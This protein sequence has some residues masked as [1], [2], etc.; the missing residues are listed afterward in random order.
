MDPVARIGDEQV[1]RRRCVGTSLLLPQM[2]NVWA[3]RVFRNDEAICCHDHLLG[4][5]YPSSDCHFLPGSGASD[6]R[7][8]KR[9]NGRALLLYPG[10]IR[11]PM[12]PGSVLV[13]NART[14]RSTP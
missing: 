9:H 2:S 1:T 7:T 6:G 3:A 12:E 14:A 4:S 8:S 10:G 5:H 11:I 13:V